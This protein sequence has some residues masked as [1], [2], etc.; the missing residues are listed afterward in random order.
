M[1]PLLGMRP[2][3]PLLLLLLVRRRQP[4]A[5]WMHWRASCAGRHVRR[6]LCRWAACPAPPV[7]LGGLSGAACAAGRAWWPGC[8][9][10]LPFVQ[11]VH[12]CLGLCCLPM[13][14]AGRAAPGR[15]R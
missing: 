12:V 6:R 11:A 4:A 10:A 9:Q 5:A 2:L 13:L 7:P 14:Q 3:L 15:R 1:R 8:R